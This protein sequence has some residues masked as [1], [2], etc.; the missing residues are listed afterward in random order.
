MKSY[1]NT[2]KMEILFCVLKAKCW[3]FCCGPTAQ[4]LMVKP[5]ASYMKKFSPSNVIEGVTRSWLFA[6]YTTHFRSFFGSSSRKIA[7]FINLKADSDSSQ[8]DAS[9]GTGLSVIGRR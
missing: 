2:L 4:L 9:I 5:T 3:Q 1:V 6:H 8:R 7:H